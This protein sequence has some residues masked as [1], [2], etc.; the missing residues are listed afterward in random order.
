M[1]WA[2]SNHG[3]LLFYLASVSCR[4]TGSKVC[5]S[6]SGSQ[7][8]LTTEFLVL[9]CCFFWD[10]GFSVT[11]LNH[12]VSRGVYQLYESVLSFHFGVDCICLKLVSHRGTWFKLCLG[13]FS[14]HSYRDLW[15]SRD[16]KRGNWSRMCWMERA[17]W[18]EPDSGVLFI[19]SISDLINSILLI[20]RKLYGTSSPALAYN[21]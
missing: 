9:F 19:K 5:S 7:C 4:S 8:F 21:C 15:N 20:R 11:A 14:E 18:W 6:F 12:W 17:V 3:S 16:F 2:W 1:N 10:G 13:A